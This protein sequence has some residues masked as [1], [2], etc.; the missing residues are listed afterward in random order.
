MKITR[1]FP[2]ALLTILLT[3]LFPFSQEA[4]GQSGE[5]VL[6]SSHGLSPEQSEWII[7]RIVETY[8]ELD[9]ELIDAMIMAI[10][11][12]SY[13]YSDID[14]GPQNQIDEA[15]A[16]ATMGM[17]PEQDV[18]MQI[19][20]AIENATMGM[21]PEQDVQ[22][23]IDEA[24]ENAT[25]G[26]IPE[27]EY[28]ELSNLGLK[29]IELTY[30]KKDASYELETY[31]GMIGRTLKKKFTDGNTGDELF[32]LDDCESPGYIHKRAVRVL[33]EEWEEYL[34][35]IGSIRGELE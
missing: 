4:Q 18:Q 10:N 3:G 34:G 17:I 8:G 32:E 7:E 22:M 20:E 19:D 15:V 23:Q 1:Y 2:Q 12:S 6:E 29:L 31:G 28:T 25:M 14:L 11:E 9:P 24:I 33:N 5:V 26:M 13:E 30:Y 27:Y 16:N 35:V 21:I